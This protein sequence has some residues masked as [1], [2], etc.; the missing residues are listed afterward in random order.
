MFRVLALAV[1]LGVRHPIHSSSAV[2][3]F[4]EGTGRASIVLRIFA[5]D[6]PPGQ[7]FAPVERYLAERFRLIDA[8][9]TR[10]PIQLHRIAMDGAVLVLT[11]SAPADGV[12]SGARIWHGVLTERFPD[13]VNLVRVH[14]DGGAATVLFTAGDGPK[15]LP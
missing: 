10:V 2:V 6:F 1:L 13:Q 11:L 15:P 9:G 12:S 8:R 3:S 5:D 4:P 14:R 7:A